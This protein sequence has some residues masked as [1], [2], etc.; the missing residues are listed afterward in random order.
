[1]RRVFAW[2]AL[3]A[4]VGCGEEEGPKTLPEPAAQETSAPER[5]RPSEVE[6]VASME[7]HYNVVILAHDALL[8][9][10]LEA[11]RSQLAQVPEQRLP[12]ASPEAWLPFHEGLQAAALGGASA[13][14]LD[15]AA[16]SLAQVVL[17]CGTCHA[18]LGMGPVYPSPP[19]DDGDT[20]VENVMR[21]HQWAT[22]RLWEGVTGPREDA[23]MRGASSLAVSQ[24]FAEA[25]PELILTDELRLRDQELREIGERAMSTTALDQRAA[26]YGRLLATCGGCHQLAG[27]EI[28]GN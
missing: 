21:E 17:A 3:L 2:V 12:D 8:Q 26:V 23:W 24:T 19:P 16:T 7:G 6:M 20:L 1:M 11:F 15:A 4:A 5:D 14:D 13:S 18:A 22:E 28:D 25:N 9:G 27:V 10:D